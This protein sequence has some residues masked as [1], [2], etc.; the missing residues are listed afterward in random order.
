[1][2]IPFFS[3]DV[4]YYDIINN[5]STAPKELDIPNPNDGVG[6]KITKEMHA[7]IANE[8]INFL[9]TYP[10][11]SSTNG[12]VQEARKQVL[13]DVIYFIEKIT[14]HREIDEIQEEHCSTRNEYLFEFHYIFIRRQL[15]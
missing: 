7:H 13:N 5:I 15:F 12:L 14:E 1:M 4:K 9:R 2:K 3:I 8:I 10:S 11:P 6:Q